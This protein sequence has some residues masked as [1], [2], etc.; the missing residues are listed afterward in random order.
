MTY[1]EYIQNP[2][3]V[4]NA[5]YSM[6]GMYEK[7]YRQKW[8][9]I[10]LRENGQ[11]KYTLLKDSENYYIHMKIPSEV[12][13]KFYYDVVV[14]FYPN[15]KKKASTLTQT[16]ED[17]NVR[18]FSNDPSFVFTFVHAF[19][20]HDMF[21]TD[22]ESK[23][24]KDALNNKAA[25]RNPKDEVGYVK[26]LYFAYLQIKKLNLMAKIK[27]VAAFSYTKLGICRSVEHANVVV[28]AR[29][30]A[31]EALQKQKKEKKGN[32]SPNPKAFNGVSA[33]SITG[34]D[35]FNNAGKYSHGKIIGK[36]KITG[37]AK[38]TARLRNTKK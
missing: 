9:A 14:Q 12:V 16:L 19:K 27:Y 17:Y 29:R 20:K 32:V 26:S 24:S 10:L 28:A 2:M 37:K 18:F 22:L 34:Q 6:R 38:I 25:E 8:D 1:G 21:L 13:P 36:N 7:M 4:H 35:G 15:K 30:E 23:M 5:V 11:I 3:G 33:S 31:G